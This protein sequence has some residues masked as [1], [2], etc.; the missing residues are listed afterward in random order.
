M[1]FTYVTLYAVIDTMVDCQALFPL[2][3]NMQSYLSAQLQLVLGYLSK[4]E[5]QNYKRK[6]MVG[7]ASHFLDG[8]FQ[9]LHRKTVGMVGS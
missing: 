9:Y 8:M 4:H 6:Y 7:E 2:R 3:W 1:G 5:R